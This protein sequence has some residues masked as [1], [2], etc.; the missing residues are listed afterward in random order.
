MKD[1]DAQLLWEAY[2]ARES[3]DVASRTPP[4]DKKNKGDFLPKHVRD[5]I[6]DED[7]KPTNDKSSGEKDDEEEIGSQGVE[8]TSSGNIKAALKDDEDHEHYEKTGEIRKKK[9]DDHEDDEGVEEAGSPG[10]V[11]GGSIPFPDG[12]GEME[13]NGYTDTGNEEI[14]LQELFSTALQMDQQLPIQ[15]KNEDYQEVRYNLARAVNEFISEIEIKT[16]N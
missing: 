6:N 14:D 9:S 7:D 15:Q 4:R 5:E 11:Q 8:E 13:P 12:R 16:H 2:L 10:R 1:K 3:D